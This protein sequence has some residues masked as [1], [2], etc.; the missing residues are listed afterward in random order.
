MNYFPYGKAAFSI[1][2]LA[3]LSGSW[4]LLHPSQKH[5]ATLTY[6]T[7]T[8]VHYAAYQQILPEFEREHPGVTVDLQLV[9]LQALSARMQSAMLANLDVPDLF[10]IEAGQAGALFRG[11][12]KDIGLVDLTSRVH[13]PGPDGAPSLWDRVVR[14]RFA[15]YTDRGH[16]YGLPHDV[17][18]VQLAYRRDIFE[19]LGIDASKIQTWDQFIKIGRKITIPGKRY[20]I[21][22]NTSDGTSLETMLFQRGG[23]YFDANGNV[24][25]DNETAVQTMCWYV[26]MV[27][28]PHKIADSLGLFTQA[29]TSAVEDGYMLCYICPDWRSK[30][31]ET[32]ISHVSGKMA[33]MPLPMVRPGTRPTSTW[34]GTMVGIT[35]HCKNPDLAWQLA[36]FFY[37]DKKG[38]A[39]RFRATN[40][41]PPIRDFWNLPVIH[42]RRPY[43]SNQRLGDTYAALANDVPPHYSSPVIQTATTKLGQALE[44]CVEYYN[45]H[46]YVDHGDAKFT[47]YVRATLKANADQVRAQIKRTPY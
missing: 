29:E 44:E 23:G 6:W 16:I 46:G 41:L 9:S 34:G 10:E 26:P 21:E 38:M 25:F 39:A 45:S 7:F 22:L 19:K 14:A 47:E 31:F 24:I 2:I 18:P 4:L 43:W 33:L 13:A 32:D 3:L 27:A 11:P 37:L 17:H 12:T 20:M 15:T 1:L 36:Q 5:K 28:G 30:N 40:I 42:E 35:K 8:P